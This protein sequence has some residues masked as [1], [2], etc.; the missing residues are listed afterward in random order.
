LQAAQ[1]FPLTA[2]CESDKGGKVLMKFN[3]VDHLAMA[4]GNMDDT[5]RFW[6]DLLGMKLVADSELFHGKC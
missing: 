6:R 3:G 1:I 4:T 2:C 5:I